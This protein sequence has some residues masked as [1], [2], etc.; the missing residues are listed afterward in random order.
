M[1]GVPADMLASTGFEIT[2]VSVADLLFLDAPSPLKRSHR[3]SLWSP[4]LT[5]VIDN[6]AITRRLVIWS[7]HT[8][9]RSPI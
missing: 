2:P 6:L 8:G 9:F 4:R 3:A 5:A 7:S 1:S